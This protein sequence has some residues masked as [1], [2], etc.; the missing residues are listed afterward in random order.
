MEA[1]LIII[2]EHLISF[3]LQRYLERNGYGDKVI[4]HLR[5]EQTK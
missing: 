4:V 5:F 2:A 1:G 3:R